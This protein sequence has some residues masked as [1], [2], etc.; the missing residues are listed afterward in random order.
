MNWQVLRH[1]DYTGIVNSREFKHRLAELLERQ[2]R[3]AETAK[4]PPA[5]E[6]PRKLKKTRS[7]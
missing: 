2:R 7:A 4:K 6:K 1:R 5:S 3:E